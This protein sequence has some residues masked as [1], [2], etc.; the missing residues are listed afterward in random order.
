MSFLKWFL[1][2]QDTHLAPQPGQQP[3]PPGAGVGEHTAQA[4][5]AQA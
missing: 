3:A 5:N 1:G 4:G 2:V